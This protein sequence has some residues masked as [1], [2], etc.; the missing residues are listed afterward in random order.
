MSKTVGELTQIRFRR[1]ESRLSVEQWA[2]V[3]ARASQAGLTPSIVLL[4]AF[5]QVLATWSTNSR[6]TINVPLMH[7][8]PMHPQINEVMGE[9]TSFILLEVNCSKPC[10]FRELAN[11]LQTQL[12]AD[13]NHHY[14]SGVRLLRELMHLRQ[15]FRGPL[16]PIVYT[17]TL[18]WEKT[19][20]RPTSLQQEALLDQILT[21]I[22]AITQTPQV[23]LDLQVHERN[24][25]LYF[26]WDVVAELFPSG[27]PDDMFATYCRLLEQLSDDEEYWNA[28]MQ[29]LLPHWQ[30]EEQARSN[31][32]GFPLPHVLLQHLFE[33][34]AALHPSQLALLAPDYSFTYQQLA[35]RVNRLARWLRAA[36][37]RPN[38]LVAIVMEK[39]WEQVAAALAIL[40][41]GAAY[42]PL[43]PSLPAQRQALLLQQG[44]VEIVLTQS[45]LAAQ[46]PSPAPLCHLCVDVEALSEWDES[47]LSAVQTPQD[48][49]YVIYTSG[50]TGQPKGVM[51]AIRSL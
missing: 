5:A 25:T 22:Y 46:L 17:S 42:V 28:P 35:K 34:Q 2:Q 30:A 9:F 3:K 43:D 32:T 11:A 24:H 8:L 13:I 40:T 4:T 36:G 44:Q 41:A 38:Q 20:P 6:F 31:A 45:W 51:I 29:H 21:E 39:G 47:P 37:A 33:R 26:N 15:G 50:S 23:W 12:W 27:L 19:L 7:R 48:L 14:V 49:A 10:S 1:W 18:V 16:M